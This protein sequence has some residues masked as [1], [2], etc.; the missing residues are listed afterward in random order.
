MCFGIITAEKSVLK[1][2]DITSIPFVNLNRL[3]QFLLDDNVFA[4]IFLECLLS[5]PPNPN[6]SIVQDGE[7]LIRIHK[8][9]KRFCNY[10]CY[11]DLR[12]H[13]MF[14]QGNLRGH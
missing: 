3:L 11:K 1:L 6:L 9:I 4:L 7:N 14:R 2:R 8:S 12:F 10:Q 13:P 5:N